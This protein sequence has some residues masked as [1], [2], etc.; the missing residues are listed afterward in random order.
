MSNV[1]FKISSALKT[2]IGKELITDDF[3]AMFELVKNSFDANAKRVDITLESLGSKGAKIVIEDNGDGMDKDD[4]VGKWLF[5]AYSAKKKQQDYRDKIAGGRIFA[6]AKGIGRFSCDRLGEGLKMYSKKKGQKGAWHVL[7]VDWSKFEA[8]AEKE[9]QNIS[10]QYSTEDTIPYDIR[11]G[12]VLEITQLRGH[13]WG[14]EKLLRLRRSLERLVNPNQENDAENFQIQLLC[15]EERAEDARIQEATE[16]AQEDV[17]AW[18]LVNGPVKNFVFESL[19]L[20]TAQIFVEVISDGTE[21]RTRLTDRGRRVYDLIE[22]NPYSTDLDGVKITLFALNQA[23][24]NAFTRRMGMRVYNYGSVFLYKNGFRIHPFGDPGDDHLGIDHRHQQ[25]FMRTLGTRDLSGRIEINGANPEFQ[26][27]S[28]R[29]GG[30]IQNKAF[31]DLKEL[32]IH[33]ALKRLETFVID[34]AKF[35]TER[36]ELPDAATMSKGEVKLAI[37]E[38]ITKLTHSTDVLSVDYDADFLNILENR[39]AE[40]VSALLGNL[41]RI[42][43]QQNSPALAKEVSKAEKQLKRLSKAKEEAEVGE[44][45]ERERAKKAES[46]ARESQAKAQEAEETARKAILEAQDAKYK[47]VQLDTQNVF[48]KAVLSKDLDHV[49]SLHHSIGQDAQ[50][51]EQYVF[52]LL[53]LLKEDATPHPEKTKVFLERIS[54]LAKRISAITRFA[55]QAN[56]LAAQEEVPG[57]LVEFVREY[58]LNIYHGFILGPQK[59]TIPI[60]FHQPPKAAFPTTFAP[61]SVSIIFDNLISNARKTQHKVTEIDVTVVEST[62]ERLVVSFCDD[63]VGIPKRNIGQLFAIGFSTTDGSGLGL[64][65][66]KELMT[67][68]GGEIKAVTGRKQ[69]AEFILTFQKR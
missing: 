65:H 18:Q 45:R 13:D 48:L 9:F 51:I 26:E 7:K 67:E 28:S 47:K 50:T 14:R 39:S 29:D 60:R 37:F 44:A 24:K 36:G 52:D 23:A 40:S 55:T 22:K 3:I 54:Y 2:I 62:P 56:H 35:G 5:V 27:T 66:I 6:G 46:E 20:R 11:H 15:P 8:D 41:K 61:I 42:A 69:G 31:S 1:Q 43:A 21:I 32:M 63:G 64:H 4:I 12:T 59:K 19:E 10:A 68:M 38:I 25:G 17:Q 53:D 49:V 34:L 58:L 16:E 33:A 57:D 30:L